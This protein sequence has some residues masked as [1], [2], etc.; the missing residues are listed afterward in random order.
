MIGSRTT[1]RFVIRYIFYKNYNYKYPKM[2]ELNKSNKLTALSMIK[3]SQT[4]GPDNS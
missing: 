3:A 1:S 2:N 4:L